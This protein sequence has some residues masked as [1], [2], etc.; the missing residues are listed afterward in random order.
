MS[1]IIKT[2][3][4]TGLLAAIKKEID[5]GKIKT[6]EYDKDGDFTHNPDQ[7]K[8]KA[9]LSPTVKVDRIEFSILKPKSVDALSKAI[10]GVYFGRFIEMVSN[11][12]ESKFTSIEL[13]F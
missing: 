13:S 3:A 10:K 5:E 8:N 12:F 1:L 9:W 2:S 6:W 7:W 11:H 4:P